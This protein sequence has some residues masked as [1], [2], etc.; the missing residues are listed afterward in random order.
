MVG[1]SVGSV[2]SNWRSL[3]TK[4]K[5]EKTTECSRT[6]RSG[7]AIAK[8]AGDEEVWFDV[9]E[10]S[11]QRSKVELLGGDVRPIDLFPKMKKDANVQAGKY[12]A[13]DCEMVGVGPDG[14]TSALARISIVNFHGQV[15]MDKYVRPAE[16]IV[17]YRTEFSGI[18]PHHMRE[19]VKLREVQEEVC[20][21]IN[22]KILVGHSLINDFKV[23]MINHPRRLVRDTAKYRP[24][25]SLSKGKTPGLKRLAQEVLG[26][27][28]QQ[29]EHDSVDDAR[30]AMLLYRAHKDV[31]EN[32]LFRQEGKDHKEK[33]RNRKRRTD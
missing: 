3:S 7:L 20:E 26:L 33:Q 22:G 18:R 16:R 27:T 24:F 31:W 17:D 6:E 28:I 14:T 12:L 19:A 11:L 25:R 2:S 15:I 30:V 5:A 21:L 10:K 13:I 32:Y 8:G 4:I 1:P 29:G 9:D 23:L